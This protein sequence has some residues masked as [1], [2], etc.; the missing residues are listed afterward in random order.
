[1]Q[2]QKNKKSQLKYFHKSIVV[3]V[4]N[5]MDI[6]DKDRLQVKATIITGGLIF[7]TL[8]DSF[9]SSFD[10]KFDSTAVFIIDGATLPFIIS[11]FFS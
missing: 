5:G 1:M 11:S 9:S 10:R 7:L 8:P 4:D 3:V 2:Q 6:S